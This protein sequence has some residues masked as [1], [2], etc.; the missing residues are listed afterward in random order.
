M[1]RAQRRSAPGVLSWLAFLG[2]ATVLSGCGSVFWS[3][4]P[5]AVG[6]DEGLTLRGL[7]VEAADGNRAVLLHLSQVPSQVRYGESGSPPS[8]T[9]EAWGPRGDFNLSERVLPQTDAL[10]SQVRVSRRDGCLRVTVEM[11]SA[12]A[13]PYTV[14]QMA[15]W[16]MIRIKGP[17]Q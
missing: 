17:G 5:A 8:I 12:E 9:V 15:D 16:V 10:I 6:A 13:P 1:M 4:T 7:Q 14:H 11:Q 2:V 3:P